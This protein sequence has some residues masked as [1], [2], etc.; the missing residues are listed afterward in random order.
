[1]FA[2]CAFAACFAAFCVCW[3]WCRWGGDLAGCQYRFT[4]CA[5]PRLAARATIVCFD[6]LSTYIT[7]TR[8]RTVFTSRARLPRVT[9]KRRARVACVKVLVFAVGWGRQEHRPNMPVCELVQLGVKGV[10]IGSAAPR[11][12][13]DAVSFSAFPTRPP[14]AAEQLRKREGEKMGEG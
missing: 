13:A 6:R 5:A 3:R 14:W 12:L 4:C 9:P 7:T 8:P 10:C 1:M 11:L 2:S